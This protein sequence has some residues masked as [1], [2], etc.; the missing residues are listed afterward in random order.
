MIAEFLQE[1][2]TG[3]P[4]ASASMH[5]TLKWYASAFGA[6][7]H[8]DHYLVRPF[9]FH[10]VTHTGRQA[11]ELQPWEFINLCLLMAQARGTHKVLLSFMIMAAVGCIRF[12]HFQ[13]SSV[14]EKHAKYLEFRCSQGKSR[15]QGARPAYAWALPQVVFQGQSLL[16]TLWDF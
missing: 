14:V 9:R 7:F 2:A 15:K 1:V 5:A 16:S 13:R 11:P 12:E 3:G 8:V 10:A 6:R 4:T